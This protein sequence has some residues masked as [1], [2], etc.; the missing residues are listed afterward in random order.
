MSSWNRNV[1]IDNVPRNRIMT[2][3]IKPLVSVVLRSGLGNRLFQIL[4]GL[5]YAERNGKQF[6]LCE[7]QIMENFHSGP[8]L[9][10]ELLLAIFSQVKVY[11]GHVNWNHHY[12]DKSGFYKDDSVPMIDGSVLLHGFFQNSC[13]FPV[14]YR[15]HFRIPKPE[16][17]K[18]DRSQIIWANTYFIHFRKG[19]YI[20]SEYDVV[21]E[22]YY[23]TAIDNITN[24]EKHFLIFSDQ[25]DKV[26]ISSW[27]ILY[28]IVP[29]NVGVWESLYLMSLCKGAIC[30]NS[31]F[32]WFGAYAQQEE[33]HKVF[34]P[35]KWRK[36]F[37]IHPVPLW[38]TSI[39]CD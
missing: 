23:K 1:V 17:C 27:N 34:M 7:N 15:K 16:I 20:D 5:G 38:A 13:H 11:R 35:K 30:A 29:T 32:S 39:E 33:E 9:T 24:L 6:V 14:D 12:E 19:D 31:T 36:G 22:T 8:K 3:C 4:A 2:T 37:G 28:T 10:K 25:P 21:S 18:F 26:E